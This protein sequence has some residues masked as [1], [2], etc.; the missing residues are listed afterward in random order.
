MVFTGKLSDVN[1]ALN[2]LMFNPKHDFSGEA[3]ITLIVNDKAA[4]D[5]GMSHVKSISLNIEAVNDETTIALPDSQTIKHG[6]NLIFSSSDGNAIR[7]F[8]HDDQS[9]YTIVLSTQH[10]QLTLSKLSGLTFIEGNGLNNS[11]MIFRG[12]LEDINNALEGLVYIPFS[13]FR[14]QDQITIRVADDA[15]ENQ[16]IAVYGSV[17]V[18]ISAE[19]LAD[20]PQESVES[21]TAVQLAGSIEPAS[22]QPRFIAVPNN[23]LSSKMED[24]YSK[25]EPIESYGG[26]QEL[27]AGDASGYDPINLTRLQNSKFSSMLGADGSAFSVLNLGNESDKESENLTFPPHVASKMGADTALP[28]AVVAMEAGQNLTDLVQGNVI[29]EVKTTAQS[30]RTENQLPTGD[31]TNIEKYKKAKDLQDSSMAYTV[32]AFAMDSDMADLTQDH[33][34]MDGEDKSSFTDV[35]KKALED[36]EKPL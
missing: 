2:G 8:D 9:N 18:E 26:Y 11:Q 10:G 36:M 34:K 32:G 23:L 13:D 27:Q 25:K 35:V 4:G 24:P 5:G 33:L 14:G 12:A 15:E 22:E 17:V 21:A 29:R 1:A 3:S 16:T 30:V 20:S 31:E 6:E 19:R 7:I 28:A